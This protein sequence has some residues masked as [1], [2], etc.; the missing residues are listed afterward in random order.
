[1]TISTLSRITAYPTQNRDRLIP[2]TSSVQ[3]NQDR[4]ESL[5]RELLNAIGQAEFERL[6]SAQLNQFSHNESTQENLASF[7][8]ILQAQN[9]SSYTDHTLSET[10]STD[11]TLSLYA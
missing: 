1:M 8:D 5:S 9:L 3:N 11:T 2:K 4:D 6:Q 10:S 7:Q